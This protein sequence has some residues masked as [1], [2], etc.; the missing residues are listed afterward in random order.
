MIQIFKLTSMTARHT[1]INHNAS[2]FNRFNTYQGWLNIGRLLKFLPCFTDPLTIW[3]ELSKKSDFFNLDG[4]L[5]KWQSFKNSKFT[6]AALHY[7]AK[8][9]PYLLVLVAQ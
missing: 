8:M 3:I 6:D 9:T 7:Y 4:L 1:N 5:K 2:N